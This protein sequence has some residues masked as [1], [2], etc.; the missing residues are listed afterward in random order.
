MIN[1]AARPLEASAPPVVGESLGAR[2]GRTADWFVRCLQPR[3]LLIDCLVRLIPDYFAYE[4]RGRLYRLA[5]ARIA[6][7]V[8]IYGRL[9]LY[10]TVHDKAKNL[11]VGVGSNVAPFCTLGVDGAVTIGCG[12]GLAPFVRIFTTQHELGPSSERSTFKVLVRP[13]T[14]ED[15]AVLMTGVTILP[16]V[17]VGRGSVV[18][19]GAV[20]TRSVPPNSFVGGVPAR[21]LK[22]LPE[23]PPE[24]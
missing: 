14:I 8:Q 11:S 22:T 5:G 3:L 12:V 13:V 20:V 21:V 24:S 15:G 7:G 4:L 6:S 1:A 9:N 23:G 17:T 19:A 16:G 2:I 10:G 18:A